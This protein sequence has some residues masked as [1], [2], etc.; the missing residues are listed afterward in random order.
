MLIR[1]G[2]TR[3]SSIIGQWNTFSHIDPAVLA[4]KCEIG[5]NVHDA[6]DR[7][8]GDGTIQL[9]GYEGCYYMSYLKW[10]EQTKPTI[11]H[12]E[13]RLYCDKLKITG[14]VDAIIQLPDCHELIIVDYKTSAQESSK[15]WPLQ[16]CFY[17]YLAVM[18]GITVGPRCLFIKLDKN[19]LAPKVFEYLYT[20]EM[21]GVCISAL[22]CY[23]Y[24]NA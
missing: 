24:L 19:G 21:M 8:K 18:N 22:N 17:N 11:L 3:I 12:K 6:I 20:K 5:T 23:R 4:A 10:K 1:E 14:A 13:K 9:D 2:Y 15:T 7:D 16:A